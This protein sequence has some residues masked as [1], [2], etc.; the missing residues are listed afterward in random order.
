MPDPV[1]TLLWSNGRTRDGERWRVL[2]PTTQPR[3]VERG[4]DYT[5]KKNI[6]FC[7]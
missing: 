1:K 7:A 5:Q 6:A 2:A 4:N 3:V